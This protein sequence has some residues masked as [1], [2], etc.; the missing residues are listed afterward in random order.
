MN[1]RSLFVTLGVVCVVM[2]FALILFVRTYPSLQVSV[3]EVSHAPSSA[4][5]PVV[6]SSEVH[7][8]WASFIAKMNE[9]L[10]P[11]TAAHAAEGHVSIEYAIDE[12]KDMT[13]YGLDITYLFGAAIAEE[14]D[15]EVVEVVTI[16]DGEPVMVCSADTADLKHYAEGSLNNEEIRDKIKCS[17][18]TLPQ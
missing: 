14:P 3:S 6:A 7:N 18:D 1:D 13:A 15:S 17:S 2:A 4:T 11:V 10:I 8:S 12:T 5:G 9:R 16:S